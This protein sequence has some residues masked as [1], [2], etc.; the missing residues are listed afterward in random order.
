MDDL[1]EDIID[2]DPIEELFGGDEDDIIFSEEVPSWSQPEINRS[3][4]RG[5][6]MLGHPE[7]ERIPV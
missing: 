2:E 5:K 4:P 6:I 1:E 7:G 3:G